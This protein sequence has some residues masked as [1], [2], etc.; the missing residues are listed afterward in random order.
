VNEADK[1]I[2]N[3]YL[4][5]LG[6]RLKMLRLEKK[7]SQTEIAYR[8]GFDKSNYNTIESGKRNPTV[9]SLL[10]IS[11]AL[12]ISLKDLFDFETK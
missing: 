8:C 6:K 3:E 7:I 11:I 9:I 1:N 10:K 12:D 2:E 5:N 4:I